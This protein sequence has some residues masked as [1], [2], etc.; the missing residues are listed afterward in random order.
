[1][2]LQQINVTPFKPK[3]SGD[4]CKEGLP[5]RLSK[6]Q[7]AYETS[8]S[9]FSNQTSSSTEICRICHCEGD[10]EGGFITPCYCAGSLRFVHQ[11]CLQQWIK[12]SGIRC[13]ELCKFQ[14]IMYSKTK[15]FME[16][17]PLEMSDFERN[18]LL[19]TLIFQIIAIICVIWT[20]YAIINATT[21]EMTEGVTEWEFW[22]KI[23]VVALSL[24]GGVLFVFAQC[25][26]YFQICQKWKSFNKV[27]Y[28]QNVP[29]KQSLDL[30]VP[31]LCESSSS[32]YHLPDSPES[33]E[34]DG[35]FKEESIINTKG[36][37]NTHSFFNEECRICL[38]NEDRESE[39]GL[40]GLPPFFKLCRA[41]GLT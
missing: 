41:L 32:Q 14:F 18:R 27:I 7:E 20:L 26:S 13:C 8:E 30:E 9:Q 22:V 21:D 6:S 29:V 2:P 23:S 25:K 24:I 11:N 3:E 33:I 38:H 5:I 10:I 36:V 4:T 17:E 37:H 28:V 16:W 34:K 15:P 31:S 12:S 1:M 35:N 39:D 19:L 40:A